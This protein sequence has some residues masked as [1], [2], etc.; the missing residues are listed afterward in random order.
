M[1]L[2]HMKIIETFSSCLN[3]LKSSFQFKMAIPSLRDSSSDQ[4]REAIKL[5]NLIDG[6]S[7]KTEINVKWI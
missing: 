5:P 6:Q 2:L 1:T 4:I 3:T 7:T